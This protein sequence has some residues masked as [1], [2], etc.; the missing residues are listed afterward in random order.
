MDIGKDNPVK[1]LI[2]FSI[3]ATI[4]ML[5]NAFDNLA[6][7]VFVGYG[8][9]SQ[10]FSSMAVTGAIF[11]VLQAFGML[12]G[13]GA[14]TRM[15]LKWGE[16]NRE[17][18]EKILGDALFLLVI[19]SFA[20]MGF[21]LYF[22]EDV[23][24]FFGASTDTLSFGVEYLRIIML[25][26][27][28]MTI[29]TGLY[30]IVRASGNPSKAMLAMI[31]SSII[32]F[33]LDFIFIFSF[34]WGVQGA[35]FSTIIAQ[36]TVMIYI[37]SLLTS[38]KSIIRLK[39]KNIIPNLNNTGE[40]L[41]AGLSS[42]FTQVA[43]SAIAAVVNNQLLHYANSYAVG[44][45][46]AINIT[47]SIF[48]MPVFGIGQGSQPVIG[49]NYGAKLYKRARSTLY[50]SMLLAF[51]IGLIGWTFFH[52]MSE[53]LMRLL[54]NSD[55]TIMNYAVSGLQKL[56][57]LFPLACVQA[58]GQVYFQS[59]GKPNIT[60][61]LSFLRQLVFLIPFF[62]IL[63]LFFGLDGVWYAV[64]VAELLS[65]ICTSTAIFVIHKIQNH[66]LNLKG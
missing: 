42:F 16:G 53:E 34:N 64:P 65:L 18:A 1:L 5:I 52:L 20:V 9:S 46:G 60:L 14:A 49:Y 7:R 15:S 41:I 24:I 2:K 3:P 19:T 32:N 6:D 48:L 47:Y 50:H 61:F 31:I 44:A 22:I 28:F 66:T 62:Y 12:I 35:A 39:L 13:I 40:I 43:S 58:V 29:G 27:P 4:G 45:Y 59:I 21:V 8:V 54:T 17:Q 33:F 55:E 23:L 56:T 25:G 57:F 11:M 63:P 36:T 37:F 10:A 38:N 30:H 26:F 51:I